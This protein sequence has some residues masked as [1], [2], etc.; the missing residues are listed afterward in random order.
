M[1]HPVL[2]KF[3]QGIV[4]SVSEG[5]VKTY[6]FSSVAIGIGLKIVI[7]LSRKSGSNPFIH[8]IVSIL[9]LLCY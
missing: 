3:L 4:L 7:E 5:T 1:Y 6:S 9:R 8:G 2:G